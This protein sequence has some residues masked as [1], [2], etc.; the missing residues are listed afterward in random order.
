[1]PEI[2]FRLF[3]CVLRCIVLTATIFGEQR[4][5]PYYT[6]FKN[7]TFP[8]G[9]ALLLSYSTAAGKPEKKSGDTHFLGIAVW[10]SRF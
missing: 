6:R 2:K 7:I 5:E 4:Y 1:M 10:L 3:Y 9:F 8:K